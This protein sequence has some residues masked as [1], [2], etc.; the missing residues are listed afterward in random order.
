MWLAPYLSIITVLLTTNWFDIYSAGVFYHEDCFSNL[1]KV[2][3]NKLE[4]FSWRSGKKH[5]IKPKLF[6]LKWLEKGLL[7]IKKA[8]MF[9]WGVVTL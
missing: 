5:N 1:L 9:F 3:W 4:Q 8:G 7:S 6:T 2:D